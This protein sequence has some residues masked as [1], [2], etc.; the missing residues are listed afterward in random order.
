MRCPQCFEYVPETATDC[1]CGRVFTPEE[2]RAAVTV[3]R[4]QRL[5]ALRRRAV[6]LTGLA[7]LVW[8]TLK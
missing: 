7:A 6:A 2:T 1:P 8:L 5:R 4:R 3:R